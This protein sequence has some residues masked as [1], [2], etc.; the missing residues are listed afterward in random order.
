[1]NSLDV[2]MRGCFFLGL[3]AL[4]KIGLLL[5]RN[6]FIYDPPNAKR[7]HLPTQQSKSN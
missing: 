6:S 5:S 7:R 4:V 3:P 2:V 1:V